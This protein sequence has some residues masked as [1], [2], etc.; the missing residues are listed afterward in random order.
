M[1]IILTNHLRCFLATLTAT[2]IFTKVIIERFK[3]HIDTLISKELASFHSAFSCADQ[4]D[5]LWI[6]MEA[7]PLKKAFIQL[8]NNVPL[9]CSMMERHF[10]ETNS[11]YQ[12]FSKCCVCRRL[13]RIDC[14]SIYQQ[15]YIHFPSSVQNREM[16]LFQPQIK[17]DTVDETNRHF[18]ELQALVNTCLR[19]VIGI[20]WSFK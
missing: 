11:N 4:I 14:F 9:E 5:T 17:T 7:A 20:L 2:K 8:Q 16:Q 12:A 13:H 3:E 18:Y 6:I 15:R 10:G 1:S 19:R